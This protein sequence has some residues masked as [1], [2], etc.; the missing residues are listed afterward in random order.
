M[1]LIATDLSAI[2]L[3]K[4]FVAPDSAEWKEALAALNQRTPLGSNDMEKALS[5]AAASFGGSRIRGRW[6]TSATAAAGPTC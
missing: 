5:A 4:G 1:R 3:T 2:P 6:S